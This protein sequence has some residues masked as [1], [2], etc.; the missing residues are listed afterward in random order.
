MKKRILVI[1][2]SFGIGLGMFCTDGLY[3]GA[4]GSPSPTGADEKKVSH[5]V[6]EETF[7]EIVDFV[8]EKWDA[9]ELEEEEDIRAAIAEGEEEFGYEISRSVENMLVKAA[10]TVKN[11]GLDGDAIADKAKELYETY[12]D[13]LAQKAE[14][15]IAQEA[16]E[17]GDAVGDAL[18]SQVVEPAKEAAVETAKSVAGNFFTDLKNSVVNFVKNIFHK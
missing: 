16:Q 1:A 3:A 12:G 14:A 10:K 8:K 13:D 15:V 18:R 5:S 2:L 9:G 17:M 6:D 4:S 11:L 7:S